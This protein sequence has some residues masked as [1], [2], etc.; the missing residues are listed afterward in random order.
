MAVRAGQEWRKEAMRLARQLRVEDPSITQFAL[1][2]RLREGIDG[3]PH[4][5][6]LEQCV[7][8]WEKD[9]DLPRGR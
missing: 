1:V 4:G 8:R 7:R 9:G 3:A 5:S 2:Q 6:G